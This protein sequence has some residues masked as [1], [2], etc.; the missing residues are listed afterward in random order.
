MFYDRDPALVVVSNYAQ[1]RSL[2]FV[3]PNDH[4]VVVGHGSIRGRRYRTIYDRRYTE[5]LSDA[6]RARQQ[7]WMDYAETCVI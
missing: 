3:F 6:E 2:R 1:Q 5:H 4:V 7:E